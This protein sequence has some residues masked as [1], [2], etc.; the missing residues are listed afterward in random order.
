MRAPLKCLLAATGLLAFACNSI[1]NDE[2]SLGT[3]LPAPTSL[4]SVS[5]NQAVELDWSDNAFE[6]APTR[7]LIYR[8]YS[9]TYD[10]DLSLCGTHWDVEGTTVAPEFLVG[11]LTNGVPRCYGISALSTDGAESDRSPLRQDTPRPDARNI[12]VY[13]FGTKPDSSG[14]RFWDDFNNDSTGQASE[15]GLIELGSAT[16][17]DLAIH[18]NNAES[19]LWIVPVYSGTTMLP[20]GRV[21]DVTS[22]DFA[23]V[24][25]YSRDSLLAQVGYG[26]VFKMVEGADV[27]YG[28]VR[29]THVGWDYVILDW[30]LQTDRGNPELSLRGGLLTAK[31]SGSAVAPAR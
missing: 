18:R 12:L 20:Y 27:H 1:T 25:G 29:V 4:E 21:A 9:A 19:S 5:L 24:S 17:I 14:F 28:A 8:V 23:P 11:A 2:V 26:Y 31:P 7:F 22:I 13:A 10:L 30:S 3:P 6:S 16:D 15:L